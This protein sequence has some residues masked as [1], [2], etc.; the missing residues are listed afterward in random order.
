MPRIAI[1][2]GASSGLGREFVRHIDQSAFGELDEIWVVAR[3]AE[4][5][6]AL[7]RT[8]GTAVR[9]FCL[10]L[11]DPISFDLL[12]G[13]LAETE[14]ARVALLVNNAGFGVFGD[15]ALQKRGYASQMIELL[16]RAPI[17]MMYRALPFMSAGSRI[18]NIASVASFIPQPRLAVYSAAKRFILDVSR[19]L[20]A[21]LGDVDIHVTAVCPKFMDTEFLK[22]PGDGRAAKKMTF[23]GFEK[24]AHVV[25][26]ALRSARAG[27]SLCI[28]SADMKALYAVSRVAPYR[29]ALKIER[30][31][32]AL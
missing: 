23:I 5:L 16:V 22:A 20:D 25:A 10:D 27:K 30:A 18:I 4:R 7:V 19:S 1:V 14:D 17:E 11:T 26:A 15:M 2:T 29:L 9:P 21:E 12:E 24:P 3:R 8:T 28:P 32:G 6:E 31:I 13:A